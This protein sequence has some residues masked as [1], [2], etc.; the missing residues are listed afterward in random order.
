MEAVDIYDCNKQ[1]KG[2]IKYR[3]KDNLGKGE[4]ALAAR[5]IIINSDKKILISRRALYK[6][7]GGYWEANGGNALAGET[8]KECVI[9]EIKEELGFELSKYEGILFKETISKVAPVFDD[10]YIYKID[11]NICD[12][13][14]NRE[15]MEVKWASIKEY[16]DLN[17]HNL[18]L[19][20]HEFTKDD[21]NKALKVLNII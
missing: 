14:P 10:I 4:Y 6:K 17:N 12:L 19:H 1:K 8:S 15:V 5:A 2:Y 20:Y 7:H 13:K 21:Y 16:E 9:R 18:I 11:I 3:G